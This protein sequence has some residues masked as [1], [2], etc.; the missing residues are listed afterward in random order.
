MKRFFLFAAIATLSSCGSDPN[1]AI[2]GKWKPVDKYGS[3][4]EKTAFTI[5]AYDRKEAI[6]F[7]EGGKFN[8]YRDDVIKGS[9]E[10]TLASDGKSVVVQEGGRAGGSMKIVSLDNDKMEIVTDFSFMN[11]HDTVIFRKYDYD[12]KEEVYDLKKKA[13]EKELTSE[14]SRFHKS[15]TD[16]VSSIIAFI[17]KKSPDN[18]QIKELAD[19]RKSMIETQ[20][21]GLDQ[22]SGLLKSLNV[23]VLKAGPMVQEYSKNDYYEGYRVKSTL[24]NLQSIVSKGYYGLNSNIDAY[25]ELAKEMKWDEMKKPSLQ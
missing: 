21:T 17:Q 10:Y 23:F 7:L 6:E 24:E 25:N 13:I 16:G 1:K 4:E 14:L 8:V 5:M 20:P 9:A 15:V 22:A 12:N 11:G 2:L 18:A 19:L 3:E